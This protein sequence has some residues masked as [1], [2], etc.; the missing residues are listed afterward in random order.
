[1]TRWLDSVVLLTVLAWGAGWNGN[2]RGDEPLVG[3]AIRVRQ[4]HDLF[5]QFELP[6]KWEERFWSDPDVKALLKLDAKA[7]AALVPQQA[8]IRYCRCPGC[9]ATEAD[10]PLKWSL[11][12]PKVVSCQRCGASYPSD[13]VP[14]A[15]APDPKNPAKKEVL[16]ESIEVLPGVVHNYPYH[17]MDPLKQAYPD[18]RLYLDAKRDYEAREFLSKAALY[19]AIRH[20]EQP[21]GSRDPSLAR[22]ASVLLLRFAQVYPAYA[23]HFDQPRSPKLFQPAN[24]PP[25]YRHRFQTG[26]WDWTASLNVPLNLVI[27]YALVRDQPELMEAGRALG[28]ARPAESIERDLFLASAEFVR[29]QSEEFSEAALQAHRGLLAV[30]RL[31]DSPAL[32]NE[33][34]RRINRFVERG[35]YYD[36]YWR[37]GDPEAHRRVLD[38]FDGWIER[39]MRGYEPNQKLALRTP[40]LLETQASDNALAA[41]PMLALARRADGAVLRERSGSELQQASWPAAIASSATRQASLL[42]GVGFGRLMVGEGA[43]TVELEVRGQDSL[44]AAHFQR[45]ALRVA[46]GG[47]LVLGDLDA[48]P[49]T[50]SGWDRATAS[51][52]T[53]VVDGLNQRESMS[54]AMKPA[55]GGDFRYFAADPDFQVLCLEDPRAYPGSTTR[56]RQTLIASSGPGANYAVSVFEVHGGLQ[57]DR[58]L[59]AA[60]GSGSEWRLAASMTSGPASLLP[61][62]IPY[63]PTARAEDGRWFVQAYGELSPEAQANLTRPTLAV[64]GSSERPSLRAHL[65]GPTPIQVYSVH[66]ADPSVESTVRHPGRAGL[67]L[68][69]RSA[70]GSSLKSTFVTLFEPGDMTQSR[71]GRL[72]SSPDTV[73]LYHEVNGAAEHLVINLEPGTTQTVSLAHGRTLRTDGLAVRLS[74]KGMV[75][76]GGTFAETKGLRIVHE[77]S[78]G[79]IRNVVRHAAAGGRGW[80]ETDE[81]LGDAR[82]LAGRTLLIQHGDRVIQAWTLRHV[83]NVNRGAKLH[84]LE[85]PGFALGASNS[86]DATYYQFP[87]FSV[88]GPHHFQISKMSRT[89]F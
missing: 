25:P 47:R 79:T 35:F 55:L 62:S 60:P 10:D 30:G 6:D 20:H 53:V 71:V 86:D 22:L 68:R 21:E 82:N 15:A 54:E 70:D 84:V 88:A 67:V 43:R 58:F 72:A 38:L 65:L 80:F 5:S 64:L 51:H 81:T 57:H 2:A 87:G 8:G 34:I 48:L 61:D 14:A 73:V 66:S 40:G 39:L 28:D 4:V 18:E 75:L 85:E 13:K 31:L 77:R 27:A 17:T 46:I 23:T 56:Y 44:G 1:M 76:A 78:T 37:Q 9:D 89:G 69:H 63:V 36:G 49:P 41:I 29:L 16:K 12:K 59:H 24:L 26:K 50:A 33:A 83:E 32:T 52:N 11:A 45:Q 3:E 7:Q 19:A 42:G 74:E